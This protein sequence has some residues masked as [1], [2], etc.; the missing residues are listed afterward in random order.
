MDTAADGV[1]V[2]D[3]TTGGAVVARRL[4]LTAGALLVGGTVY[5]H[6][7]VRGDTPPDLHPLVRRFLHELPTEQ[8]ERYAG[9]CAETVLVSDR[10]Y[11][12]ERA[13]GTTLT[14]AA[15]RA[16]LWGARL[17]VVW[18]REPGDPAHGQPAVICRS[19]ASLLEWLGIDV[20]EE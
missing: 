8:R 2:I 19:C 6:T 7:S 4:P 9:W 3:M 17:S 18:I 10:L 5:R 14:A 12:A 11:E 1:A 13:A 15:A 16:G 20:G